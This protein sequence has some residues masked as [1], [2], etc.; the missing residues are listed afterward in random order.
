MKMSRS[1]EANS[2]TMARKIFP[3]K[4]AGRFETKE[5]LLKRAHHPKLTNR[6]LTNGCGVRGSDCGR[7]EAAT[8]RQVNNRPVV[9]RCE[10]AG[11]PPCGV[12]LGGLGEEPGGVINETRM[13]PGAETQTRCGTND[14]AGVTISRSH[15]S[16]QPGGPRSTLSIQAAQ[17]GQRRPGAGRAANRDGSWASDQRCYFNKPMNRSI[18]E[19]P[20][21][22]KVSRSKL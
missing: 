2:R 21:A 14:Q 1:E 17:R 3:I 9:T 11:G 7:E 8:L 4:E 12:L 15:R 19:G 18:Q 5:K 13:P 16:S 22:V 20:G 6:V 10:E